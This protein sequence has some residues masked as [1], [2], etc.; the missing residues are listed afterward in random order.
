MMTNIQP[1]SEEEEDDENKSIR[2]QWIGTE[3]NTMMLIEE[4]KGR[5]R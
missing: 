2:R 4:G 1:R 5:M 3:R